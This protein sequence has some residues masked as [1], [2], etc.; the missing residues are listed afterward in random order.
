MSIQEHIKKEIDRFVEEGVA[1]GLFIKSVIINDLFG[2]CVNDVTEGP[3]TRRGL[4]DTIMYLHE[5]SPKKC[6]G[7]EGNFWNWIEGGGLGRPYEKNT[8]ELMDGVDMMPLE[9]DVFEDHDSEYPDGYDCADLYDGSSKN[10][11]D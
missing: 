5:N 9:Q 7:S 1:P 3:R 4:Y 2:A 6:R 8:D 10:K 11:E